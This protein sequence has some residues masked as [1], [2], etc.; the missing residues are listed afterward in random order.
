MEQA[1][2]LSVVVP[3]FNERDNVGPLVDRLRRSLDG[4][5]WQVIF[6]DDH[7][8]DGTAA[9]VK[10]M[11]AHDP[12]LLC[13]ERVGRRGLAGAVVEGAMASAAPY[14]AVIDADLQHDDTLLPRMLARLRAGD[15]DLAVGSRFLAPEHTAKG[16]TPLRRAGSRLANAL[17]RQV[18]RTEV[19]D[20][21]S[22][23]FMIRR[24]LIEAVA[25]RLS[26]QGFKVLFDIIA[27]QPAP[28]RIVEL[29]YAF[30]ERQAGTSKMD[31]R[32]VIDYL[33]LI[34][35]KFTGNVLPPRFLLFALVGASGVVVHMAMLY[36]GRAAGLS[37]M[38]SQVI[39]AVTAMSSNFLINNRVTYR[40]RRLHG[41][42]LF[43]GYLRFCALCAV[44]LVANIAI[45]NLVHEHTPWWWLAGAAGAVA[46][47]AW[48]Y[49]STA[50]A[51]W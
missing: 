33:G 3:T 26:D 32:I 12:R 40:D 11:A 21:V 20:P 28:P 4:V 37:F 14:V 2:E 38:V 47:A 44:G 25:P 5:A 45:A 34:L 10:A 8:P 43:T 39:A 51:V 1:C 35:T 30:A 16:L 36:A 48:N 31:G 50:L 6:V 7:S 42:A 23:F 46:G 9:T 18:L 24:E 29:P 22:G 17:A 27:S 41:L 49:V 13:L 19:S 15:A